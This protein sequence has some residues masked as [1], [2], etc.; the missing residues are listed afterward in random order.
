MKRRPKKDV[1]N[2]SIYTTPIEA[3]SIAQSMI[4]LV[5]KCLNRHDKETTK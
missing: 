4:M 1:N 2:K 5:L 3:L